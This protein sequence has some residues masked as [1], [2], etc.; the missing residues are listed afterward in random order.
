ML[1]GPNRQHYKAELHGF[2]LCRDTLVGFS[3]VNINSAVLQGPWLVASEDA[4]E[5]LTHRADYRLYAD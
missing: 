2:E 1:I 3:I 4:G 5:L